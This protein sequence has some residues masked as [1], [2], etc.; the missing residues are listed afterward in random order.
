MKQ[1]ATCWSVSAL[2]MARES[3]LANQSVSHSDTL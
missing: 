1:V 3:G 2:V